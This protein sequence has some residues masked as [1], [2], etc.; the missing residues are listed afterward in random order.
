MYL[1][2]RYILRS[3]I[4]P[5]VFGTGTVVFLFLMQFLILSLEQLVGKGLSEWLILKL[6]VL[7]MSWMLILAVPMG[8]LFSTL[9]A[10]G[11]MSMTHEVTIVKASGASLLRM[12]TPVIISAFILYIGLFWFNDRILPQSNL[13][14]KILMN[15]IQRKKPTFALESGLFSTQLD[16][17]TILSRHVDSLTGILNGVTIYDMT[18]YQN[19]NIISADTG[20]ISFTP[21]YKKLILD[22]SKGEIH[23]FSIST[24][25]NYKIINFDNYRIAMDAFGFAFEQSRA[26][27]VSKGDREMNIADMKVIV[28]TAESGRNKLVVKLDSVINN[29]LDDFIFGKSNLASNAVTSNKSAII[30]LDS[31]SS[32]PIADTVKKTAAPQN[33]IVKDTAKKESYLSQINKKFSK[34]VKER[35]TNLNEDTVFSEES[36][37]RMQKQMSEESKKL[38]ADSIRKDAIA[39][40]LAAKEKYASESNNLI[41]NSKFPAKTIEKNPENKIKIVEQNVV[42][43]SYSEILGRILRRLNLA[44]SNIQPDINNIQYFS[45]RSGQY[46][47][48]IFKKYSIPFACLIFVF[49]GA[50]LGVITRGG[51]FGISAGIS[52]GFYLFY[53]ACLIG[54]EKLADRGILAP[55]LAMWT[56]NII[57]GVIGIFLTLKVNYESLNLVLFSKL[58]SRKK[59]S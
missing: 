20:K 32:K 54:G 13:E 21:D 3:H 14:V 49:V 48:E 9:M 5:F 40:G 52:L 2:D 59:R 1:I 55:W 25:D 10:F 24:L 23:Q 26:D 19:R 46:Q 56:A 44:K 51:N 18:R 42:D 11:M 30:N 6:I 33:K 22:L 45:S 15:D 4:A 37:S 12:M 35:R 41:K 43:T 17:Y 47:V 36:K 8:V 7:N 39:K 53:W 58:F 27:M 29:I 16:G 38:T 31:A 57:V 28:D 50:P 34:A